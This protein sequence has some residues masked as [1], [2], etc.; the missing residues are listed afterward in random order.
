MQE[1]NPKDFA[2]LA[3]KT[4][5]NNPH[6]KRGPQ[7]LKQLTELYG[8]LIPTALKKGKVLTYYEDKKLLGYFLRINSVNPMNK[9]KGTNVHTNFDLSSKKATALWKKIIKYELSKCPT[10]SLLHL[11]QYHL[12]EEKLFNSLG[13]HVDSVQL[14]GNVAKALKEVQKRDLTKVK[15]Q[16]REKGY[17]IRKLSNP[18]WAS[19]LAKAVVEE[20]KKRPWHCRFA[21]YDE[22]QKVLADRLR[23]YAKNPKAKANR[24]SNVWVVLKGNRPLGDFSTTIFDTGL[25]GKMGGMGFE[26]GEELQG[27][28]LGLIAYETIFKWHQKKGI[29]RFQGFTSNPAVLHLARKFGRKPVG[30]HFRKGKPHYP[31]SHF[32][33]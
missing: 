28:G 13:F 9:Q 15:K 4:Q 12:K 32:K 1:H 31:S 17:R 25:S 3:L 2:Q 24:T 16:M 14:I 5:Y 22:F 26:F 18:D 23:A 27:M 11:G 8:W 29:K 6:L 30:W 20:F 7:A 33:I 21:A 19:P 10:R